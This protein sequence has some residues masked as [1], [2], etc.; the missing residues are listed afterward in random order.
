MS[1]LISTDDVPDKER[2][3]YW[4]HMMR[5]TFALDY[6]YPWGRLDGFR[7]RC[8]L[9]ELGA[10]GTAC[11]SF[12]GGPEAGAGE[13]RRTRKLIRQ[14]DVDAYVIKFLLAGAHFVI[15]QDGRAS[16]LRPGDFGI[17]DLT[18]PAFAGGAGR[19]RTLALTVPRAL[20]PLPPD[21]VA[22]VTGV[23]LSGQKGP[24]ALVSALVRRVAR[25]IDAYGPAE[26]VRISSAVLDLVAATLAGRL[27]TQAALPPDVRRSTLLRRVYAYIDE[28]LG[29][30]ALSPGTIAAAHHVSVRY[31]HK[32]F[33]GEEHTVAE[34]IKRRRLDRCRRDLSD[35]ALAA[36]PV[37]AIAARWGFADGTHFNR[38]FRAS[39]GTPP[40]EYRL[41]RLGAER[42]PVE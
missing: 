33:E 19:V 10:V 13:C 34:W 21:Q 3:D 18:R 39:H 7:A 37:R 30:P 5:E 29:D 40:G 16:C 15:A 31:L 22:E 20:L 36:R 6:G 14:E 38:V 17:S 4:R 9:A 27:Q 23:R 41:L 24:G 2:H 11:L 12:A 26:A 42:P 35:P 8:S 32:L 25:E 28:H 1:A